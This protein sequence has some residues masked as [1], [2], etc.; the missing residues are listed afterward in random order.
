MKKEVIS[1]YTDDFLK[2]SVTVYNYNPIQTKDYLIYCQI[3][4]IQ[5]VGDSYFNELNNF[6][7]YMINYTIHG[8]G[9]FKID[10][11]ETIV[12][13]GDL[14][15]V[16]NFNHHILK[17]LPNEE[18]T[19]AFAHIFESAIVSNIYR[20][21]VNKYGF[22]VKGVKQENI[23]PYIHKIIKLL[24]EKKENYEMMISSLAYE[25]LLNI[26]ENTPLNSKEKIDVSISSVVSYIKNNFD[27][28]ITIKNILEHTNYSKNHMERLFKEKMHMTMKEYLYSLRLRR[29]QE[30]LITTDLS[31]KEIA[32]ATGLSEYRAL[33]YLFIHNIGCT[34]NEF[35]AKQRAAEKNK[36]E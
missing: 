15:F 21:F 6:P 4:G 9:Y 29:A 5:K 34:P 10:G 16:Q 31:L 20:E 17:K 36:N 2:G 28:K 22:V 1:K 13:E 3:A 18:W 14:I 30:L 11:V 33:Y 27:Q 32:E 24:K 23:V 25:M 7:N 12:E 35:R 19:F 8:K 26:V